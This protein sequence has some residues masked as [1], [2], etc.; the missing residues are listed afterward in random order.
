MLS[1]NKYMCRILLH[2]PVIVVAFAVGLLIT[3]YDPNSGLRGLFNWIGAASSRPTTFTIT[4]VSDFH[5]RWGGSGATVIELGDGYIL[6]AEKGRR[7]AYGVVQRFN[8]PTGDKGVLI[9]VYGLEPGSNLRKFVYLGMNENR[10]DYFGYDSWES[11]YQ[12]KTSATV[13]LSRTF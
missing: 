6:D 11:Y 12:G 7:Y 3:P 4:N 9:E 1:P 8:Y 5:G 10:L 2:A 13:S